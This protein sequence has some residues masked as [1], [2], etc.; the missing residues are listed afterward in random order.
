M[1]YQYV[2]VYAVYTNSTFYWGH[3]CQ[4]VSYVLLARIHFQYISKL[5]KQY[6]YVCVSTTELLLCGYNRDAIPCINKR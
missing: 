3:I 5:L 1:K 6:K 4:K 2:Y